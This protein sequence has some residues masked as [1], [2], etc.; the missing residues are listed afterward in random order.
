MWLR[1][2]WKN[3]VRSPGT[4]SK[5]ENDKWLKPPANLIGKLSDLLSL[6]ECRCRNEVG[7]LCFGAAYELDV[8]ITRVSQYLIVCCVWSDFRIWSCFRKEKDASLSILYELD[9]VRSFTNVQTNSDTQWLYDGYRQKVSYR[10]AH[11]MSHCWYQTIQFGRS[12]IVIHEEAGTIP[13]D[14]N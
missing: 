12:I 11:N 1:P 6:P 4:I 7:I 14:P 2:S 3:I 10:C 13:V 5:V 9:H 8:R